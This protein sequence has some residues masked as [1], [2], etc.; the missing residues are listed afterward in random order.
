ME[1]GIHDIE[2]IYHSPGL[3]TGEIIS[4]VGLLFWVLGRKLKV[5]EHI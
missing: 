2:I 4:A 5:R 1:K 3:K